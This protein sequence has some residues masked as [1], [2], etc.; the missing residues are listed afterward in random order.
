[1]FSTHVGHLRDKFLTSLHALFAT[2]AP[3]LS[4]K[5]S[6]ITDEQ[7]S[8]LDKSLPATKLGLSCSPRGGMEREFEAWQSRRT[9]EARAAFQALLEE[10]SFIEFWGKVG[11][12]DKTE[13]GQGVEVVDEDLEMGEMGGTGGVAD[14]EEGGRDLKT[15]AK[16]IGEEQIERV[17]K[18]RSIRSLKIL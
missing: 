4:S 8:S 7:R 2:Y 18:V 17:L 13:V 14:D 6:S 16:G 15:L 3:L 9:T 12:I 10:N 5:F 1:M 11:K